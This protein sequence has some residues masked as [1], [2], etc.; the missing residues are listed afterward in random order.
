V[1]GPDPHTLRSAVGFQ[2]VGIAPPSEYT[3]SRVGATREHIGNLAAT[4]PDLPNQFEQAVSLL[5]AEIP[6]RGTVLVLVLAFAALGYGVEWLFRKA[7]QKT[8]E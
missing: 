8:Q 4:V 1:S 2:S 7:T 5:R 3:D 6:T